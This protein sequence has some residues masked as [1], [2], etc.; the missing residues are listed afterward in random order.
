MDSSE[1]GRDLRF[2]MNL[3]NN[4]AGRMVRAG[5]GW[6]SR[7]WVRPWGDPEMG[8]AMGGGG[9]SLAVCVGWGWV[10]PWGPPPHP[11]GPPTSPHCTQRE[12]QRK[13]RS[14]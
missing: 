9:G 10:W 13:Q 8:T 7:G 4:E 14:G 6:G 1:K 11:M 12:A 3:H 5:G 2:L